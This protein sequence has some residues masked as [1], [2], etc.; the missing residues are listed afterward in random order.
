MAG[1]VGRIEVGFVNSSEAIGF[2]FCGIDALSCVALCFGNHLAG[3]ALGARDDLVTAFFGFVNEAFA[4]LLGLI[5]F[6][7]SWFHWFGW[8]DVLQFDRAN[9]NAEI[10]IFHGLLQFCA[11]E[12]GDL[13]PLL[14]EDVA[15]EAVTDDTAHDGFRDIAE[16]LFGVTNLVKEFIGIADAVL[17][18]PFN[19]DD[20]EVA[21]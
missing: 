15:A 13:Y 5:H 9:L 20:L 14:S 17:N 1:D 18:N 8:G 2:T 6:I 16:G 7:E 3:L 11:R 12:V 21:C 10:E 4:L 19:V